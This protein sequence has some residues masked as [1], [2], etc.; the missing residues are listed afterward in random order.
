[1]LHAEIITAISVAGKN[2]RRKLFTG[3]A[4]DAGLIDA[5]TE[6]GNLSQIIQNT[7]TASFS[8]ICDQTE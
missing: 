7:E 6:T 4:D 3:G 5:L 2:C 8:N 1:L